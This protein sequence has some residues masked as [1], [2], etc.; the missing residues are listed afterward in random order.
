MIPTATAATARSPAAAAK[1]MSTMRTPRSA[2]ATSRPTP[3]KKAS[4]R[5]A[6]MST[7][8][9]PLS[10]HTPTTLPIDDLAC[11]PGIGRSRG[12]TASGVG[13]AELEEAGDLEDGE[14]TVEGDVAN[15]AGLGG[16]VDPDRR[17]R[18]H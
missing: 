9:H 6:S 10:G 12:A 17:G 13:K 14:N 1:A 2:N 15:D 8:K 5:S 11:D 4:P 3:P 7:G 16:G 18:S